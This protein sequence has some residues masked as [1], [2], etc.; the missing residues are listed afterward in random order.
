MSAAVLP[1]QGVVEGAV[2]LDED[3][4]PVALHLKEKAVGGAFNVSGTVL[5]K[6]AVASFCGFQD[7]TDGQGDY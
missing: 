5:H 7:Q 3:A 1:H 6:E 2:S 4:R